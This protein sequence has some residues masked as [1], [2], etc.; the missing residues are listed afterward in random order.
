MTLLSILKIVAAIGTLATGLL[1]LFWPHAAAQFVGLS[2][3]GPRGT[4]EIRTTLG[5]TFIGLGMAPLLLGAP[6]AYQV[7]GIMYL[8]MAAIRLA[9]LFIDRSQEQSNYISVA[10]EIAF[11][12]ILVL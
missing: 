12:V 3:T 10:L 1:T 11:G 2:P 5:G 7:L 6:V 9:S 4:T 8:E